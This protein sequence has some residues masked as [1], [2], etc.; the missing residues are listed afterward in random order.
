MVFLSEFQVR[1]WYGGCA[2]MSSI[3]LNVSSEL[4]VSAKTPSRVMTLLFHFQVWSA[5]L[6]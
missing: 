6:P 1:H 2:G 5:Y 3:M 4:A